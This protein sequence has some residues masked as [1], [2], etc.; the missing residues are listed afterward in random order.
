MNNIGGNH[1][2]GQGIRHLANREWRKLK[3]LDFGNF[4]NSGKNNIQGEGLLILLKR[5]QNNLSLLGLSKHYEILREL[6]NYMEWDVEYCKLQ[7]KK[8]EK[9]IFR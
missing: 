8:P 4:N 5:F 1:L 6:C 2:T 9:I 7:S 3:L